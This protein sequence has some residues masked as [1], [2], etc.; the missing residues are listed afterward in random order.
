MQYEIWGGQMPAVTMQ[1]NAGESVYTQSGG[2]SWM[3]DGISMETNMKGGFG[4]ALGRMFSRR[5]PVYGHLY[6]PAARRQRHPSPPPCP[7][8][9]RCWR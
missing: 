9:S 5:K 6:R 7:A 1:L 3:S 2:L 8:R 4:K